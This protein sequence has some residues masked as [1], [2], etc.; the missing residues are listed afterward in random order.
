[1]L[2][3]KAMRFKGLA[4]APLLAES[5]STDAVPE[6]QLQHVSDSPIDPMTPKYGCGQVPRDVLVQEGLVPPE[7]KNLRCPRGQCDDLLPG[8]QKA[9]SETEYLFC[10]LVSTRKFVVWTPH[11]LIQRKPEIAALFRWARHHT[12]CDFS[13]VDKC[14]A[15]FLLHHGSVDSSMRCLPQFDIT[16]QPTPRHD[17]A[18][19][20]FKLFD[21]TSE[22]RG[23]DEL[24]QNQAEM[25]F[26]AVLGYPKYATRQYLSTWELLDNFD[27]HYAQA[28]SWVLRQLKGCCQ[29]TELYKSL[30]AWPDETNQCLGKVCSAE[31]LQY[32]SAAQERTPG[33]LAA[34]VVIFMVQLCLVHVSCERR[35]E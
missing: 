35:A 16:A 12:T 31:C 33:F 2:N 1:M 10:G 17:L 23:I 21:A 32:C 20:A 34:P 25:A 24:S 9:P 15:G 29:D 28:V 26:G 18:E 3:V 4:Q 22:R 27:E 5:P 11:V 13:L 14:D 6:E 8:E 19:I 7:W 30:A